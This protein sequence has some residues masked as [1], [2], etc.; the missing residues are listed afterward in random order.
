MFK[1]IK[2]LIKASVVFCAFAGVMGLMA[3]CGDE[4]IT[5]MAAYGVIGTI[6][7]ILCRKP[8]EAEERKYRRR[9]AE[10][11]AIEQA[12]LDHEFRK[13]QIHANSKRDAEIRAMKRQMEENNFRMRELE[14]RNYYR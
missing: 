7:W 4:F 2:F 10:H 3:G 13:A 5:L 8:S 12:V 9:A 6:I 11:G 1:V 14:K